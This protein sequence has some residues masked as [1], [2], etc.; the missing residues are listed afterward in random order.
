M[1]K[2]KNC[3]RSFLYVPAARHDTKQWCDSFIVSFGAVYK[4]L[5]IAAKINSVLIAL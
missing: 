4:Y 1:V 5:A 3:S 2:M